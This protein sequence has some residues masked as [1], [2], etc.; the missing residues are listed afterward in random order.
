ML[1]SEIYRLILASPGLARPLPRAV[2]G[3]EIGRVTADSRQVRP[4]DLFVAVP[5]VF[6]DGRDFIPDAVRNGAAASGRLV[7]HEILRFESG[8]LGEPLAE[9]EVDADGLVLTPISLRKNW[10][11]EAL[12][13]GFHIPCIV[14][15]I[16]PASE[17]VKGEL[18]C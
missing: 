18:V 16:I 17:I 14:L 2:A 9:G 3:L 4:G 1:L 5:G 15:L 10:S 6:V 12:V 11:N 8:R 7:K 13:S